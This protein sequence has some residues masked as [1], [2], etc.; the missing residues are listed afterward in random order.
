[1][2]VPGGGGF[3]EVCLLHGPTLTLVLTDLVINLEPNKLPAAM[4]L[5][6]K[7]VGMTAPNGR[8]PIYVR[9]II[10]AGGGAPEAAQ[11]LVAWAPER[12]LFAH[13]RPFDRDAT[14]ALRRSL[15]WLLP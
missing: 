8:A 12:V 5:Y 9:L 11:K 1:M 6:A 2:T 4:R 7:L 13:G 14:S 3:R 10:H 15:D